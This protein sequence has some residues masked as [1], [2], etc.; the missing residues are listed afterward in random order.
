M[1]GR[2]VAATAPSELAARFEAEMAPELS[3][4]GELG[5]RFNVAPTLPVCVVATS[6]R[7]GVRRLGVFRW[8]LV[9]SWAADPSV[10]SR[11]INARVE[12][13]ATKPAFRK[14]LVRRRCIVPADAFY[15][16]QRQGGRTRQPFAIRRRDGELLAF[17]GLWEVWRPEGDPEAPLLRSCTIITTQANEAVAALHDRMP[18][19]LPPGAWAEWLDPAAGEWSLLR[20]LLRPAPAGDFLVYPVGPEVNNARNEGPHLVRPLANGGGDGGQARPG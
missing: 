17:A 6:R 5:P 1:C 14:A 10:G 7:T 18:A 11:L 13:V 20:R 8:G 16:W 3:G 4:D 9:P 15:E 19:V 2:F 12:T